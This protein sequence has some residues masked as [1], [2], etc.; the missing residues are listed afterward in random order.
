M[1]TNDEKLI[2]NIKATMAM[3]GFNVKEKDVSLIN[4]FLDNQITQE[5]GI[6]IIKKDIISKLNNKDV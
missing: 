5:Q 3:E 2:E 4:Q 6:Y 1:L